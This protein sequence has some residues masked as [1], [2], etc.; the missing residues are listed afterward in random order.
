MFLGKELIMAMAFTI[1]FISC[2]NRSGAS[3]AE[4]YVDK[5]WIEVHFLKSMPTEKLTEIR[6]RLIQYGV[7][8]NYITIQRDSNKLISTLRIDVQN[9]KG[10]IARSTTEFL[11]EIPFGIRIKRDDNTNEGFKVGPLYEKRPQ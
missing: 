9:G 8:L 4:F 6:E 7:I 3:E 10:S 2:D 1:A 11:D 5:D